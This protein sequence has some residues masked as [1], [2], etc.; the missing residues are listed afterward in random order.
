[1]LALSKIQT[2]CRYLLTAFTP[3]NRSYCVVFPLVC[4]YAQLLTMGLDV[5]QRLYVAG[6][7]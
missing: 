1:M 4:D 2:L 5:Q 6:T 3:L 7:A